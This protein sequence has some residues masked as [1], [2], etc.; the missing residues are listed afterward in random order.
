MPRRSLDFTS[1]SPINKKD[2]ITLV[3]TIY[4]TAT[5]IPFTLVS[6]LRVLDVLASVKSRR[7]ASLNLG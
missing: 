2:T 3:S 6:I 1:Y 4:R 5:L 7:R